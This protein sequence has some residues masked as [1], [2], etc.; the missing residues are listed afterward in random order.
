MSVFGGTSRGLNTSDVWRRCNSTNH[1]LGHCPEALDPANPTPFATC[2]ICLATGHLSS[3]C[4]SNPGRGIYVNGGSCKICSS[5]AHRAKDCP[6]LP[7]QPVRE[8]T[9]QP[10]RG[11]NEIV[12]GGGES[13]NADMGADEDDF[14]IQSREE[15]QSRRNADKGKGK[16]KKHPP[17]NN[18]QRGPKE[19]CNH[20]ESAGQRP[21]TESNPVS[22]PQDTPGAVSAPIPMQRKAKPKVVAF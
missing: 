9:R 7:N 2:Y 13:G 12:L 21:S 5:T 10:R 16:R 18:A 4:P 3:L 17:A 14:M 15:L 6:D 22:E 11:R 8:E 20:D 19:Q 1:S